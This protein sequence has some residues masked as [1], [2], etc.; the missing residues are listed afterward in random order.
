MCAG[1]ARRGLD[2][3]FLCGWGLVR[4]E[5]GMRKRKKM[6]TSEVLRKMFSYDAET[7]NLVRKSTGNTI[8]S[9]LVSVKGNNY[10]TSRVIWSIVYGFMPIA[11]VL[12][13][14][15]DRK[16]NRISNLTLGFSVAQMDAVQMRKLRGNAQ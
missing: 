10:C 2:R 13:I 8:T 15:H 14:D 3:P 9:G 11:D 1:P 6:P 12:H 7:G 5:D 4:E 16:N